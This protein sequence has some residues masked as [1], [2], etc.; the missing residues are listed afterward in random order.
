MIYVITWKVNT[1]QII[2]KE[3][4]ST[5]VIN[6]IYKTKS[7][8]IKNPQDSFPTVFVRL[9]GRDNLTFKKVCTSHYFNQLFA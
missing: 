3:K 2:W 4:A 5:D 7:Y 6:P 1:K 8:F 9:T